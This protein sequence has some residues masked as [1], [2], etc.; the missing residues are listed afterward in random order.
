[1]RRPKEILVLFGLSIIVGCST[2]TETPVAESQG[3]TPSIP[4]FQDNLTSDVIETSDQQAIKV[5]PDTVTRTQYEA[6]IID[7]SSFANSVWRTEPFSE[8]IREVENLREG[9]SDTPEIRPG[10]PNDLSVDGGV[11]NFSRIHKLTSFPG[12]TQSLFNPPDPTLCVGPNHIV[13]MVN[14]EIAFINKSGQIEFQAILGSQGNPGFFE[15]VG[16]ED[17]AIDPRCIYD[18][19]E[20]RFVVLCLEVYFSPP[21]TYL[22]LAVSDDDDPNGVWFKYRTDA[23][24]LVNGTAN[25]ADYPTLGYDENGY[26]ITGNLFGISDFSFRGI[27]YRT[28]EKT[29]LLSGQPIV[30]NDT[31]TTNPGLFTVQMA[32]CFGDSALPIG[33][34]FNSNTQATLVGL[35]DPFG[36]L[37]VIT[38][39]VSIPFFN[40]GDG[41]NN[42]GSFAATLGGRAMNAHIRDGKLYTCHT[43]AFSGRD[44]A[45]WYE[46]DL[47]GWPNG[48]NPDLSQ[49]GDIDLG[50][51]IET[52][53]PAIYSNNNG[54][55]AVTYGRS[56]QNEFISV[57]ASGRNADDPTGTMSEMF[58]FEVGSVAAQG[59]YGDYFDIAID[60]LDDLTFWAVGQTQES[61]GW[62]TVVNSFLVPVTG[63]INCDGQINLLDVQPF[64]DLIGSGMFSEKADINGDGFLNLSDVQPFV[65]LLVGG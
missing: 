52:F 1:M 49:S 27:S 22:T 31:I 6:T 35:D 63:D 7:T 21:E 60:P 24:Y 10:Q 20:N 30:V 5:S 36:N 2:Q 55:V 3:P 12:I 19:Y 25:F 15:C 26:Y 14:S 38:T 56:S 48:T 58:Q 65:E 8:E 46:F 32:Q 41:A 57:N 43:V 45:R 42:N 29:P 39:P 17:F 62:N 34:A 44:V 33:I 64:V 28:I 51:G 40:P 18:H 13:E 23:A 16:A 53:F 61:F 50:P 47:N 59:R 54:S 9:E 37:D 11:A 4:G